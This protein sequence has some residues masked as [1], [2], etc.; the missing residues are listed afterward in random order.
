MYENGCFDVSMI[1]IEYLHQTL[2]KFFF[3]SA[4][5][6]SAVICN[7]DFDFF[8]D[9]EHAGLQ[10]CGGEVIRSFPTTLETD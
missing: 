3:L 10:C 4:I 5:F 7:C 9:G 2:S 6:S 1:N 8:G